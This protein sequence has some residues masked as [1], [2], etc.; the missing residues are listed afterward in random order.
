[1]T[2]AAEDDGAEL[3]EQA[4]RSHREQMAELAAK[5]LG[6]GQLEHRDTLTDPWSV[7]TWVIGRIK[8]LMFQAGRCNQALRRCKAGGKRWEK[9][10][11]TERELEMLADH[12]SSSLMT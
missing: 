3:A 6:K 4:M 2:T 1:M 8:D 11:R 10:D 5:Y 7:K 12:L 9:Y